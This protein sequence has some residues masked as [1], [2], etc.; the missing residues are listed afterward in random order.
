VRTSAFA[1]LVVGLLGAAE[2]HAR[3]WKARRPPV[4][5]QSAHQ[6]R[7]V[8]LWPSEPPAPAEVDAERFRDSVVYLCRRPAERTPAHEVLEAAREAGV[9]P[10]LLAA[11]M[12][13][14]SR[15]DPKRRG[16]SGYGLLG[17]HPALY[18]SPGA[19]LPPAHPSEWARA[20]LLDARANLGLGARLLRMWEENHVEIDATFGG[21]PHR[22]AAS[23]MV[24]GD[25]VL[26]S[27]TEDLVF[28]SR[29]RL[30]AHYEGTAEVPQ[31]SPLGIAM[32]PP[33]E[34]SPRVATSGPG[35]DRA[36]GAR[37]HRGLDIAAS[38]GEPVRAI[39]DGTVIFAGV[40]VGGTPRRGP[41]SPERIGRYSRRRLGPGGIYLCIRHGFEDPQRDLVSCYMHL[42][43]YV[44][45]A[46]QEVRAGQTIGYVGR[47]GV[48]ASPPHL[49]IEIRVNKNRTNPLRY[50]AGELF[51]PKATLTHR[52]T[53]RAKRAR[54]RAARATTTATASPIRGS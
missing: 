48:R 44:V 2:A 40:N 29:R 36:G 13:E 7:D 27:G 28:T 32:V 18:R 45:A 26:G 33:L 41:I 17:L 11:L 6:L 10:F 3:P 38:E 30:L 20:K 12:Y 16:R 37:Q 50:L 34:G 5:P 1:L 22:S 24:W 23:H 43:T 9:D 25:I 51:P 42:E 4:A 53:A 15:C 47:T 8:R 21:T 49:H 14:Q 54:V 35:D 46:R 19:P 52:Y 39:A 31:P